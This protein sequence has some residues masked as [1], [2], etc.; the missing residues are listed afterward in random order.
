M[1]PWLAVVLGVVVGCVGLVGQTAPP[2]AVAARDALQAKPGTA[3]LTGLVLAA[4]TNRPLRRAVVELRTGGLQ[5]T[6]WVTTDADGRWELRNVAPGRY[7]ITVSSGGYVTAQY[8][9]TRPFGPAKTIDVR[10]GQPIDRLDVTLVKGG[11]VT[12]TIRDEVGQPVAGAWVSPMRLRYVNGQRKLVR[13][14]EGIAAIAQGGLTDDRGQYRIHGLAAGPYYF[15]AGYSPLAP[16]R[17]DD[18]TGYADTFFPGTASIAEALFVDV[19]TTREANVSFSLAPTRLASVSGRVVDSAGAPVR[20]SLVL[21]AL[22]TGESLGPNLLGAP[23]G[24]F[25]IPS[26]PSGD[27]ILDARDRGTARPG[28]KRARARLTAV[29]LVRPGPHRCQPE[30]RACRIGNGPPH[31]RRRDAGRA[32]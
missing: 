29:D 13:L 17:S 14:V 2:P 9:Q 12:G 18:R 3:R 21:R 16:G 30:H 1:R 27:Y 32:A 31:P 28:S 15:C 26:V 8:G 7:T 19:E 11:V 22:L 5:D 6:R 23:D 4:D 24:T 25:R 10:D 20:A